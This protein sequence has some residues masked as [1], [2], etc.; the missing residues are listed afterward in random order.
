MKRLNPAAFLV[1]AT[2]G[3]ALIDGAALTAGNAAHSADGGGPGA[4]ASQRATAGGGSQ[5]PDL[6][7]DVLPT[8]TPT[9]TPSPTPTPTLDPTP[10]PT[11]TPTPTPTPKVTPKPYLDTVWNARVYV[12]NRIGATQYNCIDYIWTRES[13]WNPRAGTPTGPYGIPQ[14]NPGTKMAT[15][16]RNWRYSPLVQVK[17]GIWYVNSRYGSACDALAFWKAHGWY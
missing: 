6:V 1:A 10:S 11:P 4:S 13:K 15:F 16:G 2:L 17:W 5:V 7:A 8:P 14:A 9:P 12:K 3:I